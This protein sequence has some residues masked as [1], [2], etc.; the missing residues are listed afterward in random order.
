MTLTLKVLILYGGQSGEHEVSLRS[1]CSV[2]RHLDR[3]RFEP[4][5]V[6]ISL[7]GQWLLQDVGQ[8][9]A[10]TEVLSIIQNGQEVALSGHELVELATGKV[11][12]TID[13]AF[14]VMHGPL[15]EDGAMQGLLEVLQV[16]YV[17]SGI[18]ASALSMD[19]DFT[20]RLAK[21][22]NLP[23]L[24]Y[25]CVRQHEWLHSQDAKIKEAL[26]WGLPVFVKPANMGS[27]VGVHKVKDALDLPHAIEDAFRYDQKVLIEKGIAAR[28]I[29]MAVLEHVVPGEPALVSLPGE[30][31][32]NHEFY[33][34]EAKYLDP[35]GASLQLPA[36]LD[37]LL[38]AQCQ[39]MAL[40]AFRALD[41]AGFARVDLFLDRDTQELY[42]NE[43]NTIPGFTSISMYPKMMM[44]SGVPY[45]KLISRLLD[46]A[47]GRGQRLQALQR[48][49]F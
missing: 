43:I 6:G 19:K 18:L 37:A 49:A 32:P 27:S 14:P 10:T 11:I 20:K 45:A 48:Q 13:V 44:H 2:L 7:K 25:L 23:V 4:V 30:I 15:C 24:P 40:V 33:S 34:Y 35:Q 9:N 21:A 5:L 36:S 47:I 41:C 39:E 38:I 46:L 28:E 3:S 8:V 31:I 29:E 12:A 22:A 17:G 16:P 1:A 26:Q 42:F